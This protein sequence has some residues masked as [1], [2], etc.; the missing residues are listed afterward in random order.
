MLS[1]AIT[2]PQLRRIEGVTDEDCNGQIDSSC[3][4]FEAIYSNTA[5]YNFSW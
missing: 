2:K 4:V 3:I 1:E 5:V